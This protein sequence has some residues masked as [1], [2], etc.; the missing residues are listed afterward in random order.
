MYG[1]RAQDPFSSIYFRANRFS[2]INGA[3]YFSTRENTLEGPFSSRAEAERGSMEYV[4]KVSA[5]VQPHHD[6]DQ[7]QSPR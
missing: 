4:E 6:H 7:T 2:Y 3:F 5:L 1:K